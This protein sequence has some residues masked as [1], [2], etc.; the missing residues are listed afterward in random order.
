M[1]N[2]EKFAGDRSPR[3]HP[4]PGAAA[5]FCNHWVAVQFVLW[6]SPNTW[7]RLRLR[8]IGRDV[9]SSASDVTRGFV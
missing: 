7:L 8:W 4:G 1:L 2:A 5:V 6:I 3:P 9:G